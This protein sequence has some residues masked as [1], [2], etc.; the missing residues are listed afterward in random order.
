MKLSEINKSGVYVVTNLNEPDNRYL[1]L[2]SGYDNFLKI[3]SVWDLYHN[4]IA[5]DDLRGKSFEWNELK[6]VENMK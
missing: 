2:I 1:V 6:G 4:C 5:N 3:E